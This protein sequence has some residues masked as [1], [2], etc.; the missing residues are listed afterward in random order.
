MKT[1]LTALGKM[2]FEVPETE[3]QNDF[4]IVRPKPMLYYS[5]TQLKHKKKRSK[6]QVKKD[7]NKNSVE[8]DLSNVD[9]AFG[10]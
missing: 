4:I 1:D 10:K 6:N 5:A 2:K 3:H 9:I 8:S 7:S